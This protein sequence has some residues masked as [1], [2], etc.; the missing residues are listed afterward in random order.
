MTT[1]IGRLEQ[2]ASQLKNREFV[3]PVS[4]RQLLD[5]FG[6]QR[7]GSWV[8]DEI[9]RAMSSNGLITRPDFDATFIDASVEIVLATQTS[10]PAP[11]PAVTA[12]TATDV[13]TSPPTGLPDPTYRISR[14]ET[15]NRPPVSVR[16]DTTIEEA[17][18]V[19]MG[20]D[21]SQLPVM[22]GERALKGVV[23]WSTIARR[24]ALGI[25]CRCAR[26]CMEPAHT[27]QSGASLFDAIEQIVNHQYVL[28]RAT[29]ETVCGIVTT[30]DL[31]MLLRQL[32]E[33]YLLLGEVENHLRALIQA[34]FSPEDLR[35]AA[36][37][38]PEASREIDGVADLNFGNY[39]SLLEDRSNWDKL[40]TKVNRSTFV[41][42]L[43]KMNTIRNDV[44]H[45]DPDPITQESLGDLRDFAKFMRD[46]RH[47][48]AVQP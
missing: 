34:R 26:D 7:R 4:V 45:F 14:L 8:V 24:L 29:D 10:E 48:G 1:G 30:S 2:I 15:A 5:W 27:V 18:T 19:M 42:R 25:P 40:H 46:L 16:P 39:V 17:V 6:Y 47:I 35:A 21:F 32:A 11:E 43:A 41:E 13:A 33:P 22:E 9:R 28:V 36:N 44:M 38:R 37:G 3:A 20:R 12:T 23:S 31:S